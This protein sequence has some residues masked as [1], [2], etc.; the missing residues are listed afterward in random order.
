M[1]GIL[2]SSTLAEC[3]YCATG[4]VSFAG[5]AV[6]AA[7]GRQGRS[8]KIER[9]FSFRIRQPRG[10]FRPHPGQGRNDIRMNLPRRN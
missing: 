2:D 6:L 1:P 10:D 5:G 7:A 4:C 3:G 9:H 8:R